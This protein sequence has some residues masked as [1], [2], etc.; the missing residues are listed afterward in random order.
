MRTIVLQSYRAH[1][2]PGWIG[3]CLVTVAKWA[4]QSGFDY[5][6]T[7]DEFFDYAPAWVRQ[8][9]GAQIFPVTDL[10]RLNLLQDYLGRGYQRVVWVDA[11]VLV[12]APQWLKIDTQAGY[13]FSHE[14][15]LGE[16]P[17]G[18]VHLSAPRINNAVMVF[19]KDHPMLAFY[20]FATE[21]ILRHAPPGEIERTVVG[22]KFLTAL[23]RAMPIERLNSVGLFTPRLMADI[24]T[25]G[26]QHC[27]AYATAF[28][29]PMGAANLCH[30]NR[31]FSDVVAQSQLDAL[32]EQAIDRLLA[33]QGQILNRHLV[34]NAQTIF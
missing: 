18:R 6:L 30:F 12:F 23:N 20:R 21:A 31:H 2:V 33:T 13:A 1:D 15:V 5:L 17:D 22:P 8:R 4:Q 10:A 3:T 19:E 26:H 34:P 32:F 7:G 27:A 16:L 11:D 9:C 25:G 29:Y 24:A 14:V 28:G